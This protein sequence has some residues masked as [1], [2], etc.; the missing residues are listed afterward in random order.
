[1]QPAAGSSSEEKR[2]IRRV[3]E[4]R[5]AVFRTQSKKEQDD[6]IQECAKLIPSQ[7]LE[8]NRS[9]I[10]LLVNV[11]KEHD[12]LQPTIINKAYDMAEEAQL[13]VNSS[14]LPVP[15]A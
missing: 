3:D 14:P 1:M 13:E 6:A 11:F 12:D 5:R 15:L 2:L 7:Y 9:A 8:V 4:L 10:S